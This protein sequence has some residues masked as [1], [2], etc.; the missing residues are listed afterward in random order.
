MQCVLIDPG[1]GIA[2]IYH[3]GRVKKNL[4]SNHAS[5]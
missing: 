2:R 3:Q 5:D 4:K 1:Q